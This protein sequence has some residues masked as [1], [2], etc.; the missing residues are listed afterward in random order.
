MEVFDHRPTFV[1]VR[2]DVEEIR[3]KM[4]SYLSLTV[5]YPDKGKFFPVGAIYAADLRKT[6][7]RH[8]FAQRFLQPG[9]DGG[10][11]AI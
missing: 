1:T 6:D 7:S 9:R 10:F 4:G 3:Y 11:P 2:S 8:R 5:A